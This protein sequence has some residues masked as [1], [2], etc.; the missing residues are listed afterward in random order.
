MAAARI[1]GV[2]DDSPAAQTGR[3]IPILVSA[4]PPSGAGGKRRRH[5]VPGALSGSWVR[6]RGDQEDEAAPGPRPQEQK[7]LL[8]V[9]MCRGRGWR[10]AGKHTKLRRRP[11]CSVGGPHGPGQLL[12]LFDGRAGVS[13]F[14]RGRDVSAHVLLLEMTMV[15]EI[16]GCRPQI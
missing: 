16:G 3:S 6:W 10:E 13:V 15:L 14:W 9:C 11:R 1:R 4:A 2:D 5:L 8:R 7:V 12:S